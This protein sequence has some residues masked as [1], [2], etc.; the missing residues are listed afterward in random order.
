MQNT[1]D[2]I[3]KQREQEVLG[4][5]KNEMV[6]QTG[7][8]MK[9]RQAQQMA[10]RGAVGAPQGIASQAAPRMMA[11][12]GIVAFAP[13]G[14]VSSQ[15][16]FDEIAAIRKQIADGTISE[17]EG[18]KKIQELSPGLSSAYR[19]K[20]L[21]SGPAKF[22]QSPLNKRG[23]DATGLQ[24]AI[25]ERNENQQSMDSTL[26]GMQGNALGTGALQG[27]GQDTAKAPPQK[28]FG[29]DDEYDGKPPVQPPTGTQ[30]EPPA[31]GLP[32]LDTN[33]AA[34]S[35][36]GPRK[37]G[38]RPEGYGVKMSD[39]TT[40]TELL[41]GIRDQRAI[42]PKAER[43]EAM[44]Y[45]LESLGMSP[46]R[47]AAEKA[48]QQALADLD[49][50]QLAGNKDEQF[51]AFL[52]GTAQAGSMAGG[53]AAA[54]NV[55]AQQQLGE[56]NRLLGRQEGERAF[57]GLQQDI[58]VKAFD[59]AKDAFKVAQESRDKGLSEL[60]KYNSDELK[61]FSESQRNL[62][63]SDIAMMESEDR[64]RKERL[65]VLLN[66]ADRQT[67][68]AIAKYEQDSNNAREAAKNIIERAKLARATRDDITRGLIAAE[69]NI[70]ERTEA[71]R[72][73]YQ[74]SKDKLLL[75]GGNEE[76]IEALDIQMNAI[77]AADTARMEKD[78]A[79]LRQRLRSM[80]DESG[81]GIAKV[82]S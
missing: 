44:K 81:F 7:D 50:R 48:R 61:M 14:P 11:A 4:L 19:T 62:L 43:A 41:Q 66:V 55:R 8:I 35:D 71:I 6:K 74:E 32:S 15:E 36:L 59:M 42:N 10:Q 16:K 39:A 23:L 47:I 58:K 33:A 63:D 75:T 31:G 57:E 76:A 60:G 77:I 25:T 65:S 56:R 68:L 37:R 30:G 18:F 52:R 28:V 21:E 27:R 22:V 34:V 45:G 3:A 13:G 51:L 49:R 54:A 70:A 26:A 78:A 69:E 1:P 38:L 67:Q 80:P 20:P 72:K 82:Q 24:A 12:G 9:Q 46:E 53:S 40:S 5:T 17:A 73:V 64:D 29:M 2:T 79:D